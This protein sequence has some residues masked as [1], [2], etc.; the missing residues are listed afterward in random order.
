MT[1][2]CALCKES[3]Y[4][5]NNYSFFSAPKDAETRRKWQNALAIKNYTVTDDTYVCSRHFHKNDIIT[6]WISGVP[7]QVIKIKYKKCRLRPGA[8]PSKNFHSVSNLQLKDKDSLNRHKVGIKNLTSRKQVSEEK[9]I[10][11]I[12]R[13]EKNLSDNEDAENKNTNVHYHTCSKSQDY[14]YN[15]EENDDL[16]TQLSKDMDKEDGD[17]SM[18]NSKFIKKSEIKELEKV[19]TLRR[20]NSSSP[21]FIEKT[22]SMNVDKKNN[23]I[24]NKLTSIKTFNKVRKCSIKKYNLKKNSYSS[25]EDR[26]SVGTSEYDVDSAHSSK[27]KPNDLYINNSELVT[28]NYDCLDIQDKEAFD[29]VDENEL[30]FEDFLEVYTEVSIPRGWSSLVTSKGHAI[31]VVYLCMGITI[32]GLPFV[33]K[34]VFIRSD[35]MLR[36]AAANKEIDPFI[37]NLVRERKH[38]KVR[39]LWD[40]EIFID[41]FDQR[42]ICQGICDPK[43]YEHFD[44][45]KV[46]YKDGIRWRD[47]SCPLIV[48]NDSSRCT[49]CAI[50]SHMLHKS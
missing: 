49:K 48:N 35:M 11:L 5:R 37:H 21:D 33:E 17:V 24:S 50:L 45:I 40:I 36:C 22:E 15:S 27:E 43:A 7:P 30:L 1:R 19:E 13:I 31:T 20:D 2:K 4:K 47:V 16:Y 39:R 38:S 28:L 23:S 12:P 25:E 9:E 10:F 18:H 41:E 8:V 44:T 42:D 3:N 29:E 46:A 32:D 34:Q 14:I 26:T 6:H